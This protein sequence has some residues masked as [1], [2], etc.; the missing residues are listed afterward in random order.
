MPDN[1]AAG[2][3]GAA[4]CRAVYSVQ[5]LSSPAFT[6]SGSVRATLPHWLHR[7]SD[8]ALRVNS[9]NCLVFGSMTAVHFTPVPPQILHT[10]DISFLICVFIRTIFLFDAFSRSSGDIASVS[11]RDTGHVPVGGHN[12][13][14]RWRE[15]CL[16]H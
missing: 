7:P 1:V 12:S 13:G 6:S 11:R 9:R 4:R 16:Q 14:P 8:K 2:V 10:I 3:V 15:P 5:S